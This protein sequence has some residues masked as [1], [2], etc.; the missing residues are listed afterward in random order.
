MLTP[1]LCGELSGTLPV[2]FNELMPRIMSTVYR[3]LNSNAL[4]RALVGFNLF[5]RPNQRKIKCFS[6]GHIVCFEP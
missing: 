5:D 2:G 4:E 1:E 6:Q 3:A